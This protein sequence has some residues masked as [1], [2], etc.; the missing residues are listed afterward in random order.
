M[1]VKDQRE[2]L[3]VAC[4]ME[5]RAIRTYERA[6]MVTEE[7]A[8]RQGIQDMMTQEREHLRRFSAMKEQYGG[9]QGPTDRLLT[10]AL[11]AE[12]LF[13]GGVMEMR[14]GQGL[15]SLEGLYTFARDSEEEAVRTYLSFAEKCADPEVREVFLAIAREE[16]AHLTELEATLA[17][18]RQGSDCG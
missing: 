12:V 6:L 15:S 2:A 14:R 10:S 7:P 17:A 3:S 9:Y 8:V 18:I 16:G 13:P 1:V 5:R 11:G 4:E